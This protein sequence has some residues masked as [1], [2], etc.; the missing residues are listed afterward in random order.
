MAVVDSSGRLIAI[1]L[2]RLWL[3]SP[4]PN[5]HDPC[6]NQCSAMAVVDS[7]GRLIGNAPVTDLHASQLFLMLPALTTAVQWRWWTR[8]AA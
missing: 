7:S 1:F 5:T 2:V 4:Q 3:T 6:L 8:Q